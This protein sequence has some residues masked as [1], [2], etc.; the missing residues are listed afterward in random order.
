MTSIRELSMQ[1]LSNRTLSRY[2]HQRMQLILQEQG[3]GLDVLDRTLAQRVFYGV[4]HGLLDI[5]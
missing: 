5:K 1:A 4:R 2:D 3:D